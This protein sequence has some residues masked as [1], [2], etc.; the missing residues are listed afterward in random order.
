MFLIF[1]LDTSVREISD[2]SRFWKVTSTLERAD[3]KISVLVSMPAPGVS[4]LIAKDLRL[5]YMSW[6]WDS[7]FQEEFS[8]ARFTLD[9]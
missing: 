4:E 3:L 5:R 6:S 8:T 1:L 9:E 7:S 2:E